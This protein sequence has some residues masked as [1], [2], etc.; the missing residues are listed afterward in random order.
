MKRFTLFIIDV[1]LLYGALIATLFIRYGSD[2]RGQYALHIKPFSI[3]F[4]LWIA[5]FYIANLYGITRFRN[6]AAFYSGLFQSIAVAGAIAIAMFYLIPFFIT[7]KTNLFIFILLFG[8]MET[9][10]RSGFNHI[11]EKRFKRS[12]AIVGL[13]TQ[14]LELARFIK[15]HP[16]TG[17]HLKY[18]VDIAPATNAS[19]ES[20]SDFGIITGVEQIKG[21]IKDRGVDTIII[22]PEAY[23]MPDVL[24]LFYRS[25]EQKMTFYNLAT[26]Y[27][28][29]TNQVPLGA[30]NQTWFLENL[31]EG[32]KNIYEVFKRIIDVIAAGLF[33]IV[34]LVFYPFIIFAIKWASAG[35]VFIR[36]K[37][38]GRTGALFTLFKFRS[39]IAN[40]PSGGAEG[41]TGATWSTKNDPRITGVGR[42]L[43]KTR[44]DE[45][46]QFWN[47]LKGEISFVGPRAERPEFHNALK[48]AIPFYE[49]RY[50]VKPGLTGWAQIN[51]QYG[52]SVQDAA[53]KLKYD[54]Y[55]LKNRSLILDLGIILRT[56][57]I[58]FRQEGR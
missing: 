47:V 53:E 1:I 46:P 48:N 49:E 34:S 30:I 7:P 23:Q 57:G 29:L 21:I 8:A 33:G 25:L 26:F 32:N 20:L 31:S 28:R 37:R 16:Q 12:I 22:S 39:M 18:L 24:D 3:L 45:L 38:L 56:I 11:V 58:I 43:R 6:T 14:S 19:I 4:I 17:Y 10:A 36:Q 35:P 15:R 27:E 5:V 44:L 55:Y 50:L 51:F 40:D 9:A 54:L 42:F 52:S 2:F 41:V 13:N